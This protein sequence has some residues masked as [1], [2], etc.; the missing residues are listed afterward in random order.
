MAVRIRGNQ[1]T[2]HYRFAVN[3]KS[4]SGDT[5]ET[6]KRRAQAVER[7]RRRESEFENDPESEEILADVRDGIVL[8]EHAPEGPWRN[9]IEK[10]AAEAEEEEREAEAAAAAAI[11][12]PVADAWDRYL[13]LAETLPG[14]RRLKTN[15]N[16]WADFAA[17]ITGSHGVTHLHQVTETM[18]RAY[19][20][21][22][23]DHGRYDKSV[24]YRRKWK[25]HE[26]SYK[27]KINQ[28][29][30]ATVA[31]YIDVMKRVFHVLREPAKIRE[32]P[33]ANISKPKRTDTTER[34]AFTPEQLRKIHRHLSGSESDDDR[35][36][37]HVVMVCCNTGLREGDIATLEW[38]RVNLAERTIEV[39]QSKTGRPVALPIF[40]DG[41]LAYLHS[42]PQDTDHV[43]PALAEMYESNPDG[44]SYRFKKLLTAL[45]IKHRKDVRSRA[46]SI[47]DVHSLRHTFAYQAA[48][49]GVPLPIV[50]SCVGHLTPRMTE[51]YSN[52]A[53]MEDKRRYLNG[54]T[55]F[56]E[57]GTD[58]VDLAAKTILSVVEGFT[59]A[60]MTR[61]A[62]LLKEVQRLPQ[63]SD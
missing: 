63:L 41:F 48:V 5:G 6:N 17:Y 60:E 52:H 31:D 35:L 26:Q 29:S 46:V 30:H 3:G 16:K 45:K 61:L 2:F 40:S 25:R 18:A 38:S 39:V 55:F 12:V 57:N 27:L 51:L 50:Q 43:Y 24:T 42:L 56:G 19:R 49:N 34:E 28:L 32:S 4:Y 33:F 14:G 22:L 44:I 62:K 21:Q 59:D 58:R 20:R 54:K 1:G 36:L 37:Y 9:Y 15:A 10:K 11:G 7:Q 53:T 23:L 47:R 8:P 13:K